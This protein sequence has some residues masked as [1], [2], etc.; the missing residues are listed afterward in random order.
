MAEL[1]QAGQQLQTALSHSRA[2][3]EQPLPVPNGSRSLERE[4]AEEAET[5][6]AFKRRRLDGSPVDREL[7][8]FSYGHYGQVEPGKLKME[9][10]SCDGG[11]YGEPGADYSASNVLKNDDSV[12]CTKDNRCNLVLRHQGATPFCLQELVIKAP[13]KGFTAP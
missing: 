5:N 11:M 1:H 10:E 8:R 6:R 3:I 2:L 9:I 12:Y 4:Y 13:K 7:K